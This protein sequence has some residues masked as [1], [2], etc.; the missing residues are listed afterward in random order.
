[1]GS[2]PPL[3][4]REYEEEWVWCSVFLTENY[5]IPVCMLQS[6]NRI[7]AEEEP[8]R[9]IISLTETS[10]RHIKSLTEISKKEEEP[11]RNIRA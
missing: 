2:G 1:M 3:S 7:P 9:N 6:L 8:N 5:S 4:V 11:N 10:K